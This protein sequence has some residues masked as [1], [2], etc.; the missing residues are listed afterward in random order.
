MTTGQAVRV[1]KRGTFVIPAELRRKFGLTEGSFM[2]AEERG[3]GILLRPAALMPLERYT[4]QRQAEF[5][6]NNAVDAEDYGRAVDEVRRMG[7]DPATVDHVRPPA[8]PSK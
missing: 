6:L 2:V 4:P 3:D 8:T 1:G 5:L 7:I